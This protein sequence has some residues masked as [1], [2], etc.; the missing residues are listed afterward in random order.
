MPQDIFYFAWVDPDE[1]FDPEVHN[2]NDDNVF[3][4]DFNHDEG[5]FAALDVVLKNPRIGLLN[6]GRKQ[7]VIFSYAHAGT[8]Y[9]IFR[10]RIVGIPS[11][12]FDTLVTLQFTARP[13]DFVDQKTTLADSMKVLPFYDSI[14]ISPDSWDD[15]DTVLEGYSKLWWIDPVSLT[16]DTS[17]ILIGEDGTEVVTESQHG[18]DGMEVTLNQPPCRA[19][20]MTATIPWQQVAIGNVDITPEIKI[21]MGAG[22]DGIISTYTG[23]GLMDDWPKPGDDFTDGWSVGIG[24]TKDL[25]GIYPTEVIPDIFSWQGTV[26]ILP[27]GSI[28]FPLKVTGEYHSGEKAGFNFQFELVIAALTYMNQKLEVNYA[29]ATDMGQTITFTLLASQQAIATLPGDDEA[30]AINLS[31]NPV[32]DP[33]EDQSIP[34]YDPRARDYAHTPRGLQSIEYLLLV[35]RATLL[36][37]A[38]AVQTTFQMLS[39]QN[40]MRL[41]SLR[42]NVVLHD[43]RLPGGQAAGKLIKLHLAMDGDTGAPLAE[44]TIASAIGYGDSVAADDGTPSYVD[45]GYMDR[46][47]QVYTDQVFVLDTSDIAYSISDYAQ[48]DDGIDF[49]KGLNRGNA[50]K[51]FAV[52]NTPDIQKAGLLELIGTDDFGN[53]VVDQSAVQSYLQAHPTQFTVRM[54]PMGTGPFNQEVVISLADLVIPKQIDL[55]AASND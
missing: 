32:S 26:P 40:S 28:V 15:P 39:F 11:N 29:R 53:K 44:F 10:G 46:E 22:L 23:P 34:L 55:E 3:S 4:F 25:S 47:C 2:R 42:K 14:F 33:T 51:T 5:D 1:E 38:R 17:D 9:P 20:T 54:V 16:V 49:I 21:H 18:R 50:I 12:V 30:I 41:M 52:A 35:A 19:V 24:F 7:W 27:R 48:F 6:A 13:V 31:A 36:A 8:V 37:K 45:E 43:H